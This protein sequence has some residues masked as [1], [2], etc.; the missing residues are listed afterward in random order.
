MNMTKMI[1][2][3]VASLL[4]LSC[5]DF[6][7]T[8]ENVIADKKIRPF[9]IR[10]TPAEAM[11]GDTVEAE[12]LLWDAGLPFQ[13]EWHLGLGYSIAN[14]GQGESVKFMLDLDS[15]AT[16]VESSRLKLRFVVPS[17]KQNPLLLSPM[18]SAEPAFIRM[19]DSADMLPNEEGPSV[20]ALVA[21]LYI[22]ATVTS[23]DFKLTVQ[24]LLTIRYSKKLE[25]G[26]RLSSVNENPRIDSLALIVVNAKGVED[27]QKIG[28]HPS[29]TLWF[30]VSHGVAFEQLP[31]EAISVSP[32]RSYFWMAATAKPQPYLSPAELRHDELLLFQ[33]FYTNLD[34]VGEEWGDQIEFTF[35]S[36][37]VSTNIACM[38]LP[39]DKDMKEFA[40]HVVLHDNRP[41]W[42]LLNSAGIDFV[43]F[44]GRFE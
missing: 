25:E 19:L 1:V 27:P 15:M 29:D 31:V 10:L 41:E 2:N 9:G 35:Y 32:E 20:D 4:F 22:D 17:G 42:M 8:Y 36:G 39:S 18:V 6:P 38:K 43:Q 3:V 13:V 14:Y 7:E 16:E 24:K 34:D 26:S 40:L 5:A 30:P 28:N 23:G 33:W 12:L 44:H 11:P 21:P 37:N